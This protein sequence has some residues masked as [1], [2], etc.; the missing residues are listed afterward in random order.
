[1][2]G[3]RGRFELDLFAHGSSLC[4]G[5][6]FRFD[7]DENRLDPELVDAAQ[8]G[9]RHSQA[10]PAVLAFQPEAAVMQVGL[11]GADRLVISVRH[12][13]ALH[14][15]L[16]GDLADTGHRILRNGKGADSTTTIRARRRTERGCPRR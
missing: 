10:D 3:S 16:A 12:E 13:V 6:G 4:P 8:P 5:L 7:L 15:L 9:G 2:T 1:M 14:G 11:E